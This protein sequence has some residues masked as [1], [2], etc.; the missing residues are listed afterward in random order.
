MDR[1]QRVS[2]DEEENTAGLVFILSPEP[3]IMKSPKQAYLPG[4]RG[5][6][7]KSRYEYC[8]SGA[9]SSTAC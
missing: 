5:R 1:R 8:S 7:L 9:T 6:S 3:A 4:L 2:E